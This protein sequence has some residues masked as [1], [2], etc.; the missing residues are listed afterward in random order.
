MSIIFENFWTWAGTVI[1][2]ATLFGGVQETIKA[3]KGPERHV[4]VTTYGDRTRIV[5]ISGA[6]EKDVRRVIE[7]KQ[8]VEPVYNVFDAEGGTNEA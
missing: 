6:T 1:L 4:R 3:A 7:A 8:E 2:A 5:E